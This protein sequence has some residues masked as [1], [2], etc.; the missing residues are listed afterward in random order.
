MADHSEAEETLL[1][2]SASSNASSTASAISHAVYDNQRVV[3]RAIGAG[4]V[5]Q[6]I[7]AVAIAQS[8]VGV[9]GLVLYC[10]PGFV[11]IKL[12]DAEV[13]AIVLRVEAR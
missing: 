13:S 2:V 5:N 1:R 10:R 7:K 12:A 11:T 9:R 8:F 3:L 6:A 4:A